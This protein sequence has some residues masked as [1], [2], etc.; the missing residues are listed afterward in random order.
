[1]KRKAL[2]ALIGVFLLGMGSGVLLDRAYLGFWGGR[3]RGWRGDPEKRQARILGFLSR[4]LDLSDA[5]RAEIA[6]ILRTT[7]KELG[8]VR[9]EA[10]RKID[11][12]LEKGGERIRPIL[13]PEQARKF[14]S[15]VKKFRERRHRRGG[16]RGRRRRWG[17]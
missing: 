4:K 9:A 12:V 3:Q 2:W 6:P 5:Q 16:R 10:F 1:M 7:W 17:H 8:D 14:E 15:L 13:N 11:R